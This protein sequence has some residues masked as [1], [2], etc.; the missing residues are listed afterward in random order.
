MRITHQM[1]K[2]SV[3]S[4]IQNN[5]QN[6]SRF[7]GM[8]SSGKSVSKPSDEPLKV[9]RIM[10]YNSALQQVKQHSRNIEASRSWLNTTEDALHHI[11][12][13][14]QRAQELAVRGASETLSPQA[15]EAIGQEVDELINTLVQFGNT[16]YAG[17][18]IFSGHLTTTKPL[19]RDYAAG[20]G[21]AGVSYAGDQGSIN[22][23]VAPNVT[24]RS[25]LTADEL[26]FS[27]GLLAGM[28]ELA[29]AMFNNDTSAAANSI[30]NLQQAG[31]RV[32]NKR[33]G[34]GAISNA[35]ELSAESFATQRINFTHLRSQLEDIDFTETMMN[36]A[37]METIYKA[38]LSS[39]ARIMQ[40]SLLDFLR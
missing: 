18:Y 34:L 1:V 14:L 30:H 31:D 7:Q 40:P 13:V 23:E 19:E 5:L 38:S 37:V 8:L 3:I 39:G 33:A 2:N 20:A 16:N 15:R 35:L 12:E 26:F 27:S 6:M 29:Q 25:N 10:G 28:E 21:A 36:F 24:V 4:N 22:W 17:R 9:A 11:T 32:L